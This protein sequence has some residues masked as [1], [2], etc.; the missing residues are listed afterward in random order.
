MKELPSRQKEVY[1]YIARY[2]VE[3]G[4]CPSLADIARGLGL[5]DS[6]IADYVNIL[7]SKGYVKSEYRVARSL[8]AVP[9]NE[10]A[11]AAAVAT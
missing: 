9:E 3:N 10:V 1:D 4:F 8:R 11:E 5:H 7:K 2:F 6:T